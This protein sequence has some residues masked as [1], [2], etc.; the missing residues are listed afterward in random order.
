MLK[1]TIEVI[2]VPVTDV[3]RAKDFYVTK[4]GLP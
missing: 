1:M 3:D 4:L 2:F